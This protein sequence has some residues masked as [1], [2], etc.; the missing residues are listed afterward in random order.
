MQNY[1]RNWAGMRKQRITAQNPKK[2]T[3]NWLKRIV[4]KGILINKK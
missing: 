3:A 4:A 2:Y 1:S